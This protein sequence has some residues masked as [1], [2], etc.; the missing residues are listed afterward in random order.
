MPQAISDHLG[1]CALDIEQL[2][3]VRMAHAIP[4]ERSGNADVVKDPLETTPNRIIVRNPTVL[5]AKN[6]PA[7]FV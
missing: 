7:V 5:A 6:K 4:S 3:G 1:V 2:S